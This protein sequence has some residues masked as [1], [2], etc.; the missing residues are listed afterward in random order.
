ML[1]HC[2]DN[3]CRL[4]SHS[5]S[6]D[7]KRKCLRFFIAASI[8]PVA[9]IPF[10]TTMPLNEQPFIV[11]WLNNKETTLTSKV[12]KYQKGLSR[13][14]SHFSSLQSFASSVNEEILQSW[15]C[16]DEGEEP[17]EPIPGLGSKSVS[18]SV[19]RGGDVELTDVASKSV[20]PSS[21]S[22]RKSGTSPGYLSAQAGDRLAPTNPRGPDFHPAPP[23]AGPPA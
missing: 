15:V 18:V 3:I 6:Y 2:T 21:S 19:M 22:L 12:E 10:R 13:P 11:H 20:P 23:S 1:T 7:G 9:D 16:I 17:E 8:D 14:M 4:W 5:V